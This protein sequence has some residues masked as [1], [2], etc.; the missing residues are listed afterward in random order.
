MLI[1]NAKFV[2]IFDR[3]HIKCSI[4]L[5][6]FSTHK[7]DS[8]QDGK[9]ARKREYRSRSMPFSSSLKAQTLM[10]TGNKYAIKGYLTNA[11]ESKFTIKYW[12]YS[13]TSFFTLLSRNLQCICATTFINSLI[14]SWYF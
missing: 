6:I 4:Q 9:T 13:W 5:K 7:S 12:F 14:T 10:K 11:N 1:A 3:T 2:F 8:Q